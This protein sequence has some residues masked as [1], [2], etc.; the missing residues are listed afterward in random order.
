[1]SASGA[2]DGSGWVHRGRVCGHKQRRVSSDVDVW[3]HNPCLNIEAR[4]LLLVIRELSSKACNWLGQLLKTRTTPNRVQLTSALHTG[5]LRCC[6][7]PSLQAAEFAVI[8][9]YRLNDELLE[10]DR[11]TVQ[12]ATD[13]NWVSPQ[14]RCAQLRTA[15]TTLPQVV[16]SLASRQQQMP[17]EVPYLSYAACTCSCCDLVVNIR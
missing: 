6:N 9:C 15:Q 14:D 17:W 2:A 7:S 16:F 11:C 12:L 1:M 10:P 13:L 8:S 3:Q 4:D 5:L